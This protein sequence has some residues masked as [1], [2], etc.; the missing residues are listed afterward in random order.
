MSESPSPAEL[1]AALA[2]SQAR[3]RE[4]EIL[5]A[6]VYVAAVQLGLPQALLNRV[7][8]I[9]ARGQAPQF[10]VDAPS[11]AEA[12]AVRQRVEAPSP[13]SPNPLPAPA[14]GRLEQEQ[15]DV[16][17]AQDDGR[18][19]LKPLTDRRTLLLVDDDPLMLAVIKGILARENFDL[20]L[21]NSGG[22]A[23]ELLATRGR[24]PLD[25]LVVD[26]EMPGMKGPELAERVRALYP[27]IPVLFQTGF[28]DL[29]FHNR[30][31][32]AD[33][34]AFLEKPFSARGLREAV[35]LLLLGSMNQGARS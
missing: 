5:C 23:L 11:D 9:A 4:L 33:G 18:T 3:V 13:P 19:P 7:W 28:S 27:G 17:M 21:A 22:E 15:L 6:E 32:L 20:L 35:R 30:M 2:A 16:A 10:G 12:E 8:T 24:E 14:L 29:L 31:E 26:V 1:K 25:M 34:Q